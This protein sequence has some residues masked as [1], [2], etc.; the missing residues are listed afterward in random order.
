MLLRSYIFRLAHF[1]RI[2]KS[3]RA[4]LVILSAKEQGSNLKIR[5]LGGGGACAF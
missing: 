3:F 4:F 5:F 1:L 2:F